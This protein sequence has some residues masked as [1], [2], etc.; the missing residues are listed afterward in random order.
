MRG[1]LM[2]LAVMSVGMAA[3]WMGTEGGRV[4]TAEGAR[5]LAVSL[6]PRPLPDVP[7]QDQRGEALRFSDYQG[8]PLL[9]EFIYTRCAT[10]C[11]SLGESFAQ[12]QERLPVGKGAK[13]L[14]ISF[15]PRDQ[16]ADLLDYAER[17]GARE[18]LWRIAR[19]SKDAD[20]RT[21][22][23]TFEVTVIADEFGGFEHNA[24]ILVVD[25]DGRL[26]EIV[27]HQ[28]VDKALEAL[29]TRS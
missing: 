11:Q 14:S 12:I 15:D 4:L 2:T 10:I 7:L 1:A 25:K 22:L 16:T 5:R 17:N 13:L 6:D 18:S 24:A 29:W 21:L 28:P 8:Q 27:D 3:L 23:R 9:V 20:L 19:P 26:V